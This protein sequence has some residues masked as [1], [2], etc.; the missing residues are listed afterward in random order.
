MSR[1]RL[2]HLANNA[3]NPLPVLLPHPSQ[4]TSYA[5][6]LLAPSALGF[7]LDVAFVDSI[8]RCWDNDCVNQAAEF[9]LA[10]KS[11]F[12]DH[13]RHRFLVDLDGAGFSGRFLPFLNSRSLVFKA[14][15][16]REWWD[17]RLFA[18]RHFVPVDVRFHGLLSTLAYFAG[19]GTGVTAENA[20]ETGEELVPMKGNVKAAEEIAEAGREWA[21]K[22][23]RKEDIEIYMFRLLLEWAR[24]TDDRRDELGFTAPD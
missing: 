8:V 18:W 10:N 20:R 16:F 11:D 12:Q 13:W 1:Q 15:V 2:V 5:Y 9:G 19:T 4:P 23:L 17:G 6:R 7:N 24:L 22:L 3:T 14:A 21:G